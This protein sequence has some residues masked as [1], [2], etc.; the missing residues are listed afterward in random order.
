MKSEKSKKILLSVG[1]IA[2]VIVLIAG[3]WYLSDSGGANPS[4]KDATELAEKFSSNYSGP[5]GIF[6]L[7][8]EATSDNA[9]VLTEN[10][11]PRLK[12]SK[13]IFTTDADAMDHFDEKKLQIESVKG[14]MGGF[15]E[16]VK[17]VEGFDKICVYKLDVRMEMSEFTM[18][19]FV[20]YVDGV[21]IESI[22]Y[23][24]YHPDSLATESEIGDLF[25]SISETI[26]V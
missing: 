26:T 13:M 19:Y 10:D 9:T 3:V 17:N 6:E 25:K 23:P 16:E 12:Y 20:A 15:P 8:P 5:F 14:F 11:T 4:N 7:D 1:A 2:I 21:L 18:I 24:L 22:D